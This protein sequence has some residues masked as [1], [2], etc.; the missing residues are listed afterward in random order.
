MTA[1]EFA[2][3]LSRTKLKARAAG[4]ARR[5]LVDGLSK[6]AAAREVGLTPEAAR[7][8]VTRVERE[9]LGIVGCPRNW[10]CL[11]VC[12]PSDYGEESARERI[13]DIERAAWRAAGL[14]V[15]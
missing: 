6:S 14:L 12:V 11:T 13:K 9:H 2:R 5:V 15:N 7:Q 3:A 10:I 8:A 4:M 1:E